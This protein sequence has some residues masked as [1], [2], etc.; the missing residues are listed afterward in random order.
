VGANWYLSSN[1]RYALNVDSTA[2][3]GGTADDGNRPSE[4]LLLS[5]FQVSG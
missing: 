3:E 5:R 2:F 1:L 4:T